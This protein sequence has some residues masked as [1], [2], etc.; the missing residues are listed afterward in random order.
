M[1]MQPGSR[2]EATIEAIRTRLASRALAK[3]DKLPSIRGFAAQI[4]VSPST[5]VE[6]YERLAAEGVIRARP[7]S[8][9]YVSGALPP[10]ALADIAPRQDR[11]VDPFWVSRLSLDSDAAS[12]RPG[13]G[14][15]P[16]DFM[17]LTEMRRALRAV[18]REGETT[19]LEYGATRGSFALRR[20]L[21]RHFAEEGLALRPE[22]ILLTGSGTQAIDLICRFLLQ[23]G[24]TVLVDDPCYFNFQALLRAHRVTI[25]GVPYTPQGPDQTAMATVLAAHR[26]R[27]YITNS[28]LHNPTGAT[29][30][31]SV[32]HRLLA[33]AAAHDLT[34]VE[35]DIFADLEP[36][37]SV[38]LAVLDGLNRVIRIGSF[39]KTISA[40][41]RCGFIAARPDWLEGLI[42][43]QLATNFGGPSPLSAETVTR[44][45]LDR[46]YS[47]HLDRLRVR[48]ARLRQDSATFLGTLGITPWLMP[49]GGFCLW[50]Q[51][52]EGMDSAERA[53]AALAY[54]MVL[55]PGNVFSVAQ[56]AAGFMR[57]NVAE[58]AKP[59]ARETLARVF[60]PKSPA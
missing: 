23:P 30:T 25:L 44:M 59:G 19:L 36:E 21:A 52:P 51:L 16:P 5:V 31:P 6:A 60:R 14:W 40:S 26:P 27:L 38:R 39:S 37:R 13:C 56:N 42:D 45:L 10:L 41:V 43:M 57:F 2:I 29:M 18:T 4:G 35:D 24:D 53:R 3:G 50:C 49:R 15:L 20:L 9:F 7:G 55:A 1:T 28:A 32:A 8:G 47:R 22:E 54:A 17:P 12:L 34:I 11:S 33:L 58:L 46:D 48:L